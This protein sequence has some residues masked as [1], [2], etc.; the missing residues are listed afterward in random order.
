MTDALRALDQVL[1][2]RRK[3]GLPVDRSTISE[4]FLHNID[5]Y[6]LDGNGNPV[7][8]I[9]CEHCRYLTDG[10]NTVGHN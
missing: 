10:I 6:K 2:A 8:K 5:L 3:S 7:T 4:L 1:K 9:R